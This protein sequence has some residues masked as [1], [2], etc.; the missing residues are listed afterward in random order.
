MLPDRDIADFLQQAVASAHRAGDALCITGSG[1]KAFLAVGAARGPAAFAGQLLSTTEHTGI[2]DYRAEELVITARAGT[3]LL[4]LE[5]TLAQAGQYLP[6]EPPRMHGGGTLGGA[7]AAGLAGP[8][9]PWWGSV[10]D[11]VLGVELVNGLG[12]RLRFGGQVMKNVAGYDLSRLQ[13]GAFGTLGLLLS[14][15]VKVLPLPVEQR[16]LTFEISAEA[17]LQRCRAW[18]RTAYPISATCHLDGVLRVRLSGAA[19]AI[20]W[21]AG[22]LGGDGGGDPAFWTAL[23]DHS[24]DFLRADGPLWRVSLPPAAPRPLGDG[25]L[26]W[27][28]AERW[29]RGPSLADGD[30]ATRTAV[31]PVI[32]AVMAQVLAAGGT[33][34]RFDGHFGMPSFDGV[35]GRYLARL[36]AAFDPGNILNPHLGVVHAD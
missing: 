13:V 8:G 17:A 14:V 7:I 28:G 2:V 18:A 5:R 12:E 3:P 32:P 25:L 9:R 30:A 23:R 6:F 15:S 27:S 36:K 11:C 21:A 22:E 34:R 1:S 16:T 20:A 24:L 31:P 26:N 35:P 33:A 19:P 29:W 10:R 4:Q